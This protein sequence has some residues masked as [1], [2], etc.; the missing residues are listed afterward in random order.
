MTYEIFTMFVVQQMLT[1]MKNI[2]ILLI[3]M[4]AVLA[5]FGSYAEAAE[6]S[7][8]ALV[9]EIMEATD[10]LNA[11]LEIRNYK[12]AKQALDMLF[13]LM[14][15][16][17][18]LAKKQVSEL[19]KSGEKAESKRVANLLKK[20]E[21]IHDKLHAMVDESSAGLRVKSLAVKT[22]VQEYVGLLD[23]DK[24]LISSN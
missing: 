14:K 12:I 15:K 7:D 6:K 23:E 13:P 2:K 3:S 21:A 18:K 22:L 20:K 17:M 24:K 9:V 4:L 19:K 1:V 11:A 5:C 10:S 8:A 16:E